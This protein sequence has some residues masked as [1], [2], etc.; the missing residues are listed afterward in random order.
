MLTI[1]KSYEGSKLMEKNMK[2]I[3]KGLDNAKS[4]VKSS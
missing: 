2:W 4:N 3:S 1:Y